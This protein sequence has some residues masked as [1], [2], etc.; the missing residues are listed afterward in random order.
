[1][2]NFKIAWR[3]VM[4]GRAALL[5]LLYVIE[6]DYGHAKASGDSSTKTKPARF[7][8]KRAGSRVRLPAA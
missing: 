7:S 2:R 5:P 3:T 1:M 6:Q 8:G 4:V